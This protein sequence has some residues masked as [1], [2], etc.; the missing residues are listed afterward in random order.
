MELEYLEKG[1]DLQSRIREL[2][3][4]N[5]FI[6]NPGKYPNL[7][8]QLRSTIGTDFE[9][10]KRDKSTLIDSINSQIANLKE[11]FLRL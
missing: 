10:D 4:I 7:C 2:D 5:K 1:N 6:Q 8:E 11:E 9:I 3:K